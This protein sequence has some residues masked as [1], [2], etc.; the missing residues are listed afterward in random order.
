[1]EISICP[2]I[3]KKLQLSFQLPVS[4]ITSYSLMLES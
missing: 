3:M 4:L 2:D 1:M